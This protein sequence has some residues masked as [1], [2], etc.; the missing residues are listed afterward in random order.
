M[1][2]YIKKI[3]DTENY[4][5][6]AYGLEAKEVSGQILFDRKIEKFECLRLADGDTVKGYEHLLPHLYRVITREGAPTEKQI[7][8][9]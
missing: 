9:G 6:Y 2:W 1:W 4:I 3:E 5:V 7:A 8:I